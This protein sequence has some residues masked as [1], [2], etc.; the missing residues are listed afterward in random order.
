[1]LYVIYRRIF[2]NGEC[3]CKLKI[4]IRNINERD[5]EREIKSELLLL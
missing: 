3:K 1:M 5:K 2:E 4:Y